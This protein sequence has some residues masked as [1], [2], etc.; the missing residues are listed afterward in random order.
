MDTH[1]TRIFIQKKNQN[2]LTLN[3]SEYLYPFFVEWEI[4]H[5]SDQPFTIILRDVHNIDQMASSSYESPMV[6]EELKGRYEIFGLLGKGGFGN[7]WKV[8]DVRIDKLFAMKVMRKA[9]VEV[10]KFV[11][12]TILEQAIMRQLCHPF[13]V[14]FHEAFQTI[15]RLFIVMELLQGGSLFNFVCKMKDPLPENTIK[16]F[17]PLLFS[18]SLTTSP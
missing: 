8:R 12:H 3:I 5:E 4:E 10:R 15:D 7:V 13:I 18:D 6:P 9:D 11:D 1:R 17:P 2:L 14:G 16:F